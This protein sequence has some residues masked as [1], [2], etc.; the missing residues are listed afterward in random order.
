[1]R[2]HRIVMAETAKAGD[3][4][5][6][7]ALIQHPMVTGHTVAG[8]NTEPRFIIHT[9]S[10]TYDGAQIFQADFMP[11]IAANPYV[12]FTMVATVTGDVAFTWTD[13]KGEVTRDSRKL[14][15]S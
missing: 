9:L 8:A 4:I 6:V 13:D 7:K 5:E 15:V 2:P 3:V 14:R 10:V 11:G 12:A 1:M